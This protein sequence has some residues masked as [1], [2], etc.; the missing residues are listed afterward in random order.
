MDTTVAVTTGEAGWG[1]A[2]AAAGDVS[3]SNSAAAQRS[4][5]RLRKTQEP[6]PTRPVRSWIRMG[7]TVRLDLVVFVRRSQ[8]APDHRTEKWHVA[9]FVGDRDREEDAW[10]VANLRRLS[11]IRQIL[12]AK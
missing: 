6:R 4:G 10:G 5:S 8:Q 9:E 3:N 11:G 7:Y 1:S 2:C 12:V